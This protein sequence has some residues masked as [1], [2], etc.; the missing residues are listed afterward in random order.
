MQPFPGQR[1]GLAIR[2][3]TPGLNPGL[4]ARPRSATTASPASLPLAGT[5]TARRRRCMARRGRAAPTPVWPGPCLAWRWPWR[6]SLSSGAW[7]L[8]SCS[9][10]DGRE[11]AGGLMKRGWSVGGWPEGRSLQPPWLLNFSPRRRSAGA[12]QGGGGGIPR[13]R[14]ACCFAGGLRPARTRPS[15][16][17]CF[18][19]KSRGAKKACIMCNRRPAA[20]RVAELAPSRAPGSHVSFEHP[21]H[22]HT[23]LYAFLVPVIGPT[24]PHGRG[25]CW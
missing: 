23:H 10:S 19:S 2:V 8:A 21:P 14:T 1:G 17:S 22:T 13:I 16:P 18:H 3:A 7:P 4:E 25:R 24:N 20:R 12:L 15:T 9:V 6:C 11:W 5:R